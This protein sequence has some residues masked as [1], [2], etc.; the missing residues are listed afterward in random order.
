MSESRMY[1]EESDVSGFVII[2]GA[3]RAAK[4][5]ETGLTIV[6]DRG[7][8]AHR[9][10][11]LI[12]TAGPHIDWVKF[13]IGHW[14]VLPEAALRRKIRQLR[15]AG[16][17]VFLAG[18]ASEAAWL[19]GVS[20]DYFAR[21]LD[22]GAEGVEVSSAQVLM[23]TLDKLRLINQAAA[24]GLKVVAEAGRK[25]SDPRPSL[26]GGISHEIEQLRSV[27]PWRILVQAEGITEGVEEPQTDLI[28]EIVGTFGLSHLIFQAKDA[29]IQEFYIRSFGPEVSL[30]IEDDQAVALELLRIGL[31]K[32][33][34][35]GLTRSESTQEPPR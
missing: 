8:G 29:S 3:A 23:P 31:R 6:A 14:R 16:I 5:R 4:P 27:G 35:A 20:R 15:D 12:E 17:G 7:Y 25:G 22:V 19:Q 2:R 34:L 33:A 21:A 26:H 24:S 32:S 28:R 11:D 1:V 30:D 10:A 9:I 13:A 18:D